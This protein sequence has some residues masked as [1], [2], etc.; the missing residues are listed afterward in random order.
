[1]ENFTIE[2]LHKGEPQH[3]IDLMDV[4]LEHALRRA[5]NAMFIMALRDGREW[6]LEDIEAR[7]WNESWDGSITIG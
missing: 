2:I 5:K 1:M 6:R 4:D 3:L 7:D